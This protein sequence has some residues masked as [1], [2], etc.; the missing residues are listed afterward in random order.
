LA[1]L[2]CDLS[3]ALTLKSTPPGLE[4]GTYGLQ[5]YLWPRICCLDVEVGGLIMCATFPGLSSA[6]VS[7][8]MGAGITPENYVRYLN[9]W[10]GFPDDTEW[11]GD[12]CGCPDDRCIGQHH[13]DY[14]DCGCLRAMCAE[15]RAAIPWAQD[16][17]EDDP[18]RYMEETSD[19]EADELLHVLEGGDADSP[20][21]ANLLRINAEAAEL[22]A[23]G[24]PYPDPVQLLEMYRQAVKHDLPA[25]AEGTY[26]V[27]K[28]EC[29]DR[30]QFAVVTR[31]R[32]AS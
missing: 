8:L 4:P 1:H 32:K 20:T 24:R 13:Y 22:V 16:H 19:W 17:P 10:R 14:E 3:P 28:R 29:S 12:E 15:Y 6:T 27:L 9:A 25:W 31:M 21:V 7:T 30:A 2:R 26:A 11:R 23:S 18:A 5:A